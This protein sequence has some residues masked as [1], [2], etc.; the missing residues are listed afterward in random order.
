NI[1]IDAGESSSASGWQI[2][3][4]VV[5]LDTSGPAGTANLAVW[6]ELFSQGSENLVAGTSADLSPL[7]FDSSTGLLAI[8]GNGGGGA[9][10][11]AMSAAGFL[12]VTIADGQHSSDPASALFDPALA[13]ASRETLAGIRVEG[14]SGHVPL[15]LAP[16]TIARG[17]TVQ[18]DGP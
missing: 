13:G 12:E 17:L 14:G 9:V 4:M 5:A 7:H 2:G 1:P 8:R 10:R 15:A 6:M 16:Q 18:T 3:R 11:E